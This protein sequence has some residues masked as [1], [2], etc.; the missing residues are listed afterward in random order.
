M[1]ENQIKEVVDNIPEYDRFFT[2]DELKERSKKLAEEYPAVRRE[3]VGESRNGEPLEALYIGEGDKTA[4]LFAMPHPNEPIGSMTLDYL[5]EVLA[6]DEDLRKSLNFKF[7]IIKCIDPDGTRLNEGWFAG[8]FTPLNYASN[9]YRPPGHQQVEWTFPIDYKDLHYDEPIKE[10]EALME[11]MEEEVPDFL[12]SLHNAGFGGAYFYLSG[13][14][15]PLYD[16]LREASTAMDIPLHL[17]EP[18]VPYAEN[19]SDAIYKMIATVE[20]YDYMEKYTDENPAEIIN[21][22]TGST[23]Y[24]KRLNEDVF[25][26][27]C[28]VPYF[29]DPKIGNY[30]ESDVIRREAVLDG[31]RLSE[32]MY[33]YLE[34]KYDNIESL[35]THES[36][37]KETIDEYLRMMEQQHE[38][39]R[40]W[41]EINDELDAPATVSQKFDNYVV[42]RFYRMLAYGMFIRMIGEQIN[43]TNSPEETDELKKVKLEVETELKRHDDILLG[44]L[45]YEVIPIRKLVGVQLRAGLESL[46]YVN[47]RNT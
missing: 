31:V 4:L 44:D 9:F 46:N 40:G 3:F 29:F 26:L 12:Y 32:D 8:P 22:G 39:K 33:A 42:T 11:I 15:E 37:F 17:G 24:A 43:R 14:S 7:I 10:T 38:S 30:E 13:P 27:V 1:E 2:V 34:E 21:N 36:K 5:S 20:T 23:D 19:L 47:E 41:A 18:E 6:R 35:L 45:D 25:S 28:E 16:K